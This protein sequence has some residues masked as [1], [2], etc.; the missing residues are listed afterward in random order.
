MCGRYVSGALGALCVALAW[1]VAAG[2]SDDASSSPGVVPENDAGDAQVDQLAQTDGGAEADHLAPPDSGA[3]ADQDSALPSCIGEGDAAVIDYRPAKGFA[4]L[5]FDAFTGGIP[6]PIELELEGTTHCALSISG[7]G[8]ALRVTPGAYQVTLR[9]SGQVPFARSMTLVDETMVELALYRTTAHLGFVAIPMDFSPLP[10]GAWRTTVAHAA[11]NRIDERIDVYAY[12]AGVYAP[13][14]PAHLV[15]KD[16]EFGANGT[17]VMDARVTF[18]EVVAQGEAPDGLHVQPNN[19][20]RCANLPASLLMSPV[21]CAPSGPD[22]GSECAFSDGIIGFFWAGF[23][24]SC[25]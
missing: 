10:A 24:D 4:T 17:A 16:L 14:G 9:A 22:A 13:E 19:L 6:E 23:A 3:E 12:T 1:L 8:M 15:A 11:V 21:F 25:E 2:C 5:Y 20:G 18:L 7:P